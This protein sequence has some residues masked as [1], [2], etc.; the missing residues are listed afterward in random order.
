MPNITELSDF[1]YQILNT[2][3]GRLLSFDL[4][5]GDIK[6][7]TDYVFEI[8][9]IKIKE[10]AG[11]WQDIWGN[12]I[13]ATGGFTIGLLLH[14]YILGYI[15]RIQRFRDDLKSKTKIKTKEALK[16]GVPV[17]IALAILGMLLNYLIYFT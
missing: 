13:A 3:T 9:L 15:L 6:N 5:I 1:N 2:E 10:N 11:F 17:G 16:Y 12:F 14:Q 4:Y 8:I 7:K